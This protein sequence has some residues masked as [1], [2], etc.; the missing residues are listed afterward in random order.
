MSSPATLIRRLVDAAPH[1]RGNAAFGAAGRAATEI[2]ASGAVGSA[3]VH[4]GALTPPTIRALAGA[5]FS[6][7]LPMFL[8]TSIL[9]TAVSARGG[10][11][12]AG[13]LGA[14]LAAVA[15]AAAVFFLS[16]S[17]LFPAFGIDPESPG[18]R[19]L[20]VCCS[21]GNAG[22]MP[23][24]FAE[25][26]FRSRPDVL[27]EC[28]SQISLFLVGWSPFFWSFGRGVMIPDADASGGGTGRMRK[29]LWRMF[30]PPV[31][32]TAAGLAVAAT[33][34][35]KLFVS[36]A[37]AGGTPALG[38]L[39]NSLLNFGRAANPLALLVLSSSLAVGA[40]LGK[41]DPSTA[42]PPPP[43][44]PDSAV[45]SG[46]SPLRRLACISVARS[47]VSPLVM[48]AI[49]RILQKI[50]AVG[51]PRE[52]P[53]QW[54][55]LLLESAVPPAQNSVLM[56]QVAGRGEEAGELAK[57]LLGSYAVSSVFLIL[58]VTLALSKLGLA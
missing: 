25:A 4:S 48:V 44:V 5:T 9:R 19:S 32:G 2:A 50:G 43:A 39:Y 55:V 46:P 11:S 26:L 10:R 37:G 36:S 42:P 17:V 16:R 38:A 28:Y 6:V 12:V 49:L 47:L 15:H 30:P 31:V 58:T 29:D 13:Q 27:A 22:T 34:L 7:L 21:F 53:A 23:L 18:G 24:I 40:G 41:P 52:N 35:R 45:P 54:F 20:S 57:F 51:A 3:F 56:L 1:L 8:F 14:P 33:P